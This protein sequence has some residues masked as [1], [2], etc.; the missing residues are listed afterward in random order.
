MNNII[1]GRFYMIKLK[2]GGEWI[3][4]LSKKESNKNPFFRYAVYGYQFKDVDLHDV[5]QAI[6]KEEFDNSKFMR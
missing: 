4:A 6:P 5:Y 2:K 1:P 3:V